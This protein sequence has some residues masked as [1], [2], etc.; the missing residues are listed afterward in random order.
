[1]NECTVFTVQSADGSQMMNQRLLHILALV[2]ATSSGA[3]RETH[4]ARMYFSWQSESLSGT[5]NKYCREQG[6]HQGSSAHRIILREHV[7]K[8]E[9]ERRGDGIISDLIKYYLV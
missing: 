6:R 7:T 4:I 3:I 8:Q 1:M 9:E 2:P 5:Y